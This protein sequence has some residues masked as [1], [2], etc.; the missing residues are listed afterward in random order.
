M[1]RILG[2]KG[3]ENIHM[4]HSQI[5][6]WTCSQEGVSEI[7]TD[8]L[9]RGEP[10]NGSKFPG[11]KFREW[12]GLSDQT[13]QVPTSQEW[14]EK[15]NWVKTVKRNV[16][17]SRGIQSWNQPTKITLKGKKYS[18]TTGSTEVKQGCQRKV[19]VRFE[20]QQEKPLRVQFH[21]YGDHQDLPSRKLTRKRIG[22]GTGD[23]GLRDSRNICSFFFSFQVWRRFTQAPRP[24]KKK[25]S[26]EPLTNSDHCLSPTEN[27]NAKYKVVV[28]AL[29]HVQLFATPWTVT[30]QDPFCPPDFPGKNTGVS[31]HF[32]L[33]GSS[34]IR[35]QTCVSCI[36]RHILYHWATREDET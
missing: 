8:M 26:N 23:R 13:C 19:A 18:K 36:G 25:K 5:S 28:Q 24:K 15:E 3:Y 35:G 14:S 4:R 17:R 11:R 16:G 27:E 2:L 34:Q 7:K 31:C 20:S 33:W 29:S 32:L 30:Y 10:W 9:L 12:R 6:I 21:L 22:S 1:K